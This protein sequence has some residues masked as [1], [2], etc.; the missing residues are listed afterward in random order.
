MYTSGGTIDYSGFSV[1]NVTKITSTKF[2]ADLNKGG[3]PL[4]VKTS[5]GDIDLRKQ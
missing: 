5:G 2:E 1:N 4:I 3:N